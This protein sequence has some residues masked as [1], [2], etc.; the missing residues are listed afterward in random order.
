MKKSGFGRCQ[1]FMSNGV[2]LGSTVDVDQEKSDPIP[3]GYIFSRVMTILILKMFI[4]CHSHVILK[5][6]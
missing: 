5:P 2:G 6:F 4:L 1:H 3:F